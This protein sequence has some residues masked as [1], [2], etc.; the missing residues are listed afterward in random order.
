MRKGTKDG[1]DSK[2]H[3]DSKDSDDSQNSKD[4]SKYK[5]LQDKYES[6]FVRE[7]LSGFEPKN[8]K[9]W[10]NLTKRFGTKISQN[11]L[12]SIAEVVSTQLNIGLYR[13]YKRRKEMLIKWFDENYESIWP[14]IENNITII[15]T[16]G[17]TI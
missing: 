1:K 4:S 5:S 3:K 14:F 13:E 2:G 17:T 9:A 10:I 12:L 16:E 15:D 7:K 8:S 6:E 11:Q